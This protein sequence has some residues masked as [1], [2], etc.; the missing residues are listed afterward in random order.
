MQVFK[1]EH[2]MGCEC[3]HSDSPIPTCKHGS[4]PIVPEHGR[5]R[6]EVPGIRELQTKSNCQA[7]G[8]ARDS[9]PVNTVENEGGRHR[10]QTSVLYIKH[11]YTSTCLSC[12]HICNI[13]FTP[14]KKT[15][16]TGVL[17]LNCPVCVCTHACTCV[18]T[19][20]Y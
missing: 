7:P 10:M 18:Y 8:S 3:R 19:R 14:P 16:D 20:G 17:S 1:A 5:W 2:R 4:S 11:I 15:L 6:Q 12:M 13:I 9:V